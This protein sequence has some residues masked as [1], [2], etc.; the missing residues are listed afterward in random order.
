[1]CNDKELT[2]S[3][4]ESYKQA[5]LGSNDA[6]ARDMINCY[7]KRYLGEYTGC[8]CGNVVLKKVSYLSKYLKRQGL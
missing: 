1:M 3:L 4:L 2:R 6:G 7:Y 5:Y 8:N